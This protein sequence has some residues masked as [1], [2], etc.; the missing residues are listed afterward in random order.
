MTKTGLL[1]KDSRGRQINAFIEWL[2]YEHEDLIKR[3]EKIEIPTGVQ[4]FVSDGE[5][6]QMSV[7]FTFSN[8]NDDT[9]AF[10]DELIAAAT[11]Y[12]DSE[13]GELI[14]LELEKISA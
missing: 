14:D 9:Q 7:K 1:L 2:Y 6:P 12:T 3:A 10:I 5:P 13:G 8:P 4:P 11:S